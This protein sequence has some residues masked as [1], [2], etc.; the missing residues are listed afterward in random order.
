MGIFDK[1]HS[2]F[3]CYGNRSGK[4]SYSSSNSPPYRSRTISELSD[5]T[6][7]RFSFRN[8]PYVVEIPDES[9]RFLLS[10]GNRDAFQHDLVLLNG[11]I[12]QAS[13]YLR[14]PLTPITRTNFFPTYSE[15]GVTDYSWLNVAPK[16]KNGSLA[17]YPFSIHFTSCSAERNRLENEVFGTIFYMKNESIGKAEIINWSNDVCYVI[18]LGMIQNDLAILRVDSSVANGQKVRLFDA[19]S[20]K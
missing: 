19:K 15:L 12:N 11:Y 4:S 9:E 2:F 3:S 14:K 6:Q 17:K 5:V 18:S 13:T 1:V 16:C 7:T 10:G 8:V 20:K